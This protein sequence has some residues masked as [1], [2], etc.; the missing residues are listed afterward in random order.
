[1]KYEHTNKVTE[2]WDNSIAYAASYT[3]L[4]DEGEDVD[5]SDGFADGSEPAPLHPLDDP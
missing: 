4:K 2:H 3:I 1:M 5:D